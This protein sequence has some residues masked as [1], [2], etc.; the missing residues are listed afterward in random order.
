M[1]VVALPGGETSNEVQVVVASLVTPPAAP[2]GLQAY[3]NGTGVLISWQPGGGGPAAGYILRV[4]T[5]PGGSD[6]GV[7]P[8]GATG[9]AVGGGVPA[10]IYYLAVSAVNAGGQSAEATTVLNMPAGGA[11]DAPPAPALTTSNWGTFLTASWT[12][13]PGAASYLLSAAGPG[14][15]TAVPFG[16]GT[17][18]FVYPGL[19]VGTWNF[20]IQARFSC[21]AYGAVGSSVLNMDGGSLRMQPRAPD[22]ADNADLSYAPGIIR[23]VASAYPGDLAQLVPGA[24]RQQ[25]LAVP[26]RQGAAR[27]RQALGSQ[28]EAGQHRRHVAGRDHLQLGA[29]SRRRDLQA[30]RVGRHRRPLRIAAGLAVLGDHQ[31]EA[32]QLQLRG[33]VDAAAVHPGRQRAVGCRSAPAIARA[34]RPTGPPASCTRDCVIAL[35][36]RRRLAG[37][38]WT[39]ARSRSWRSPPAFRGW[40]LDV[41]FVDAHSWRQVTNADIARIWTEGPIDFFYPAV[42]WGGPDGRTGLEF[43]LLHWLIA[44]VWRVTGVNDIA[45]RL[46]PAAF[47]VVTVWLIYRLGTRLLGAPAGRAA[48]FLLAVSPTVIYFGR[49]PLSDTPMLCFS[50]AA[51][52]GYVG[53]AQT[54]KWWMALGGAISLALAGLVKIPAILVLAPIAVAGWLRHGWRLWRDEWFVAAPLAALGAIGLWYLHADQI[55]Q[56]TGLTQAIFR[57]SGTY[58]LD[59][60]QWSGE[61]TTVSHWTRPDQ[62]NRETASLLL[63]QFWQLHL[64]PA[65]AVIAIIGALRWHWPLAGRAWSS[66]RGCSPPRRWSPYRCRDRFSTSSTSC[67]RCRRWLCT[68]G[69]ARRHCST[70]APTRGSPACGGR[71]PLRR[72]RRC[73]PSSPVRGFVDSGVIRRLYRPD[74]LN[75]PLVDAGAAIDARTPKAALLATVEYRALRQQLADAALLRASQ[76]LELR[77][78][79]DLPQRHRVPADRAR[80]LLRRGRRLAG[81]RGGACGRHRVPCDRSRTSIC[82]TP[83]ECT[84]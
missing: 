2:V 32:A 55:Y 52:L 19:P 37:V 1:K 78:G 51:V 30:A 34:D 20:G 64:T 25:P 14:V 68:S 28:L 83:T 12:P 38:P 4:G 69:W 48:A 42:S 62:L 75:T 53:Y 31:P 16:G 46:V 81:P 8:T 61:F 41:P 79:V 43:P 57:P 50:V 24:R 59:I 56:E 82:P 74:Q 54:G 6:L 45:G 11:C 21:G 70:A 5:S 65:F 35:V 27:A 15:N 23:S 71:W 26:R 40:R 33:A 73:S 17:T 58:P 22:P 66:T 44:L 9:L 47:S 49:T 63:T 10:G 77:S 72:W 3:R 13:V 29:G 7:I 18:S 60:A 39:G 36:A 80:R 67:R 76:G 84:N